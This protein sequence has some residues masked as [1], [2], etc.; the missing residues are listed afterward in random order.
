MTYR[1]YLI[2]FIVI[3]LALPLHSQAQELQRYRVEVLVLLHLQHTEPGEVT[4]A[5]RDYSD[6]LDLLLP[7]EEEVEIV[8]PPDPIEDTESSADVLPDDDAAVE[9]EDIP[10]DPNAVVRVE[11]M[12]PEMSEAWRRLRLSG[13]FRPLQYL[14]WEQGNQPPFP[15]LRLRDEEVVWVDDPYADM[16][17]ALLE[18]EEL[19]APVAPEPEPDPCDPASAETLPDPGQYEFALPDPTEY[20]VLDGSVSLERR[21][22]L[23]LDLDFELRERLDTNDSGPQ[24]AAPAAAQWTTGR[25]TLPPVVQQESTEF[26]VHAMQQTRQVRSGRMEYFDGPV[27]GVLAW[28][29]PIAVAEPT[30]R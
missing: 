5:L 10:P 3:F 22:F 26:L 7:V 4:D 9:E 13:P 29:T 17:E 14:S 12:G 21:R 11:E 18:E 16:R 1:L 30:E 23:H 20:Y 8:C 19:N 6:T 25:R 2:L 15:V 24:P 28:I 27:I